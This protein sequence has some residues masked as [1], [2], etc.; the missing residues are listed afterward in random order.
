M[1]HISDWLSV[2]C[3]AF[4]V[5]FGSVRIPRNLNVPPSLRMLGIEPQSKLNCEVSYRT[6]NFYLQKQVIFNNLFYYCD[7]LW[8]SKFLYNCPG[9]GW[10]YW[11]WSE[12]GH[13]WQEYCHPAGGQAQWSAVHGIWSVRGSGHFCVRQ[14]VITHITWLQAHSCVL[15]TMQYLDIFY[16]SEWLAGMSLLLGWTISMLLD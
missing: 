16:I 5:D 8:C 1:L 4:Y 7:Y 13:C 15:S 14:F 3:V 11:L 12:M 6:W 9:S 2:W 10:E